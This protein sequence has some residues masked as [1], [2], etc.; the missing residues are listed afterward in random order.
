M[1]SLIENLP[2]FE[3]DRSFGGQGS[4]AIL[5][6]DVDGL[7]VYRKQKHNMRRLD[8]VEHELS[9]LRSDINEILNIVRSKI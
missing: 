9:A 6:K 8:N 1:K 7:E 2:G 4:G 5:N 3:K